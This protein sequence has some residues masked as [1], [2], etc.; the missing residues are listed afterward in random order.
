MPHN[1]SRPCTDLLVPSSGV[2]REAR[3]WGRRDVGRPPSRLPK[4]ALA[5]GLSWVRL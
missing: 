2:L 4:P 5:E 1:G 3:L